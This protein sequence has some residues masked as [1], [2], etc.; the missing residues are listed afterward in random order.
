MQMIRSMEAIDF[1]SKASFGLACEAII[2]EL[3]DTV[4]NKAQYVDFHFLDMYA[5]P[6]I[7]KLEALIFK[8]FGI[9]ARLNI[10]STLAT[11]WTITRPIGYSNKNLNAT[12]FMDI[13]ERY[14]M[15]TKERVGM[16][17][18]KTAKVSGVFSE[19]PIYTSISI[20]YLMSNKVGMN[21]GEVTAILLHELGH[22]FNS[23]ELANKLESGN[24]ALATFAS[25][26][27]N[28]QPR[29][30]LVFA[31]KE[32][33]KSLGEKPEF[34]SEDGSL[35]LMKIDAFKKYFGF[36]RTQMSRYKYDETTNESA[37][38][39]FA[40]RMGYGKELI[41]SLEKLN[42]LFGTVVDQKQ[43]DI[44]WVFL[45][46]NVLWGSIAICMAIFGMILAPLIIAAYLFLAL[47]YYRKDS[48]TNLFSSK[49]RIIYDTDL[50]RYK[51]VRQQIVELLKAKSIPADI[52]T[53]YIE[54]LNEMDKIISKFPKDR[55]KIDFLAGLFD[56]DAKTNFSDYVLQRKLEDL[57]Y[58]DLFVTSA[59]LKRE[60]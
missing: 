60:A 35:L 10:T 4:L 36:V 6:Y 11:V 12:G 46:S 3:A 13:V 24:L 16:V 53:P 47:T 50:D 30:K 15:T 27:L 55:T 33:S 32:L 8:R 39:V 2:E 14:A 29:E 43:K 34:I 59:L 20:P 5:S 26:V 25:S 19:K 1:Q 23:F 7:K 57:A 51:R 58:S 28:N 52:A 40:T 44:D 31:Y 37:A 48:D 22:V 45:I 18:L 42:V 54:T 9:Q 21:K 41:L 17:D 56:P 38:D 49:G